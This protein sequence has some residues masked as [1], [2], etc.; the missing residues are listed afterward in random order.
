M[1]EYTL[2]IMKFSIRIFLRKLEPGLITT[3]KSE[4]L[5]NEKLDT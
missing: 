3:E 1:E 4:L 2:V 5:I